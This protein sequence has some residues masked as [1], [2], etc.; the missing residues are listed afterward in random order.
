VAACINSQSRAYYKKGI[1][2]THDIELATP[3]EQELLAI[4]DAASTHG[5]LERQDWWTV[6]DALGI[7][8]SGVSLQLRQLTSPELVDKGIPQ[9]MIQLLPF[10][11]NII[12]KLGARGNS[13]FT[14]VE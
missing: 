6:I 13:F 1:Y 14:I 11:P 12:T 9:R 7:S 2:P 5:Y 3:N 8:L 10:I 4:Y